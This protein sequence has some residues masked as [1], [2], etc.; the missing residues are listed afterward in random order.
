V[1][2][3]KTPDRSG[4]RAV[5]IGASSYDYLPP[6]AA[7]AH[8]LDRMQHLLT[9]PLCG[10]P[11]SR[12][13]VVPD[14]AEP[15]GL[16]GQL[17]DWYAEA[18]DVALFYYV[19]HGQTDDEDELCLGLAGSRREAERRAST[20]LTFH[21][22]RK[23]LRASPAAVKIV[24]LDCCFAGQAMRRPHELTGQAGDLTDAARPT[25][26]YILAATGPYGS[27]WFDDSP[28]AT[29]PY[30]HFTWHLADIVE[31]GI[32][33]E[34]EGLAL[35][36]I[37][38]RLRETLVA[39]GKSI[40][41]ATS[42]D[43]PG[44]FVFARNAALRPAPVSAIAP[45]PDDPAPWYRLLDKAEQ[46]ARSVS[47]RAQQVILLAEI[48]KTAMHADADRARRLLD[49]AE[50][51][52]TVIA[53][54]DRRCQALTCIAEARSSENPGKARQALDH[55][56]QLARALEDKYAQ[57]QALEDVAR[58]RLADDPAG[59]ERTLHAIRDSELRASALAFLVFGMAP[60]DPDAAE[61]IARS[62][63]A[64]RNRAERLLTVGDIVSPWDPGRAH[65]IFDEAGRI[66]RTLAEED[67]NSVL[68]SLA[69]SLAAGD[70][71]GAERIAEEISDP[72]YK[73]NTWLQ[74]ATRRADKDE[75]P[76]TIGRLQSADYSAQEVSDPRR[77]SVLQGYIARAMAALD[78]EKAESIARDIARSDSNPA[79]QAEAWTA[80][81][82]EI[83]K[84]DPGRAEDRARLIV[85]LEKQALALTTVAMVLYRDDRHN[86][87]WLMENA[88]RIARAGYPEQ[89]FAGMAKI[90]AESDA[91]RAEQIAHKMNNPAQAL[92]DIAV[93]VSARDS[94]RAEQIAET[95]ADPALKAQGLTVLARNLSP[96]HGRS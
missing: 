34:A 38:R 37:Y 52:A 43:F 91:D 83:A 18:A 86:A 60:R 89:I 84:Y 33:G 48:A 79:W 61:R 64:P 62:I 71:A 53:E 95:V 41:V 12:V 58:V 36:P 44:G 21:A 45:F 35:E 20:S 11:S 74:V 30:T 70:P 7:A 57:A 17:A 6:I 76:V 26:A 29:V 19:G 80:V 4:S 15:G 69:Q 68:S 65:R 88:E 24:I 40:P 8:S 2:D 5:L 3:R 82:K 56:D 16:P 31:R 85:D 54:P 78:I 42:H 77:R 75:P 73:A 81:V 96:K 27:A 25:G 22:V 51:T 94:Q 50:R 9:G 39:A 13:T 67:R 46:A 14:R 59:A 66:A 10:W 92:K 90:T 28:A 49:E 72:W 63:S 93:I 55:A 47:N 23:A 1:S 87:E 32:P